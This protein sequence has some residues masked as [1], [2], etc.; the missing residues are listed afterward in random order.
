MSRTILILL[1]S[2]LPTLALPTAARAE[3]APPLVDS[4]RE[5][6]GQA[7]GKDRMFSFHAFT[8]KWNDHYGRIDWVPHSAGLAATE[9]AV[10][11]TAY[12]GRYPSDHFPVRAVLRYSS[13]PPA[14]DPASAPATSDGPK[15]S[16]KP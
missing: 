8:G 12:D 9:S 1:A 4:Y 14:S 11:R 10:D 6:P 13:S 15:T 7:E 16:A 2:L 5:V 3:D